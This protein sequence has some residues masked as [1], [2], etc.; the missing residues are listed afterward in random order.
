MEFEVFYLPNLVTD[1]KHKG[2]LRPSRTEHHRKG[3]LIMV[4]NT[5]NHTLNPSTFVPTL[6]IGVG[7]MG[8]FFTLRE[9]E[10]NAVPGGEE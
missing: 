6:F 10:L 7:E 2:G 1:T 5:H 9:T 8:C 3:A 4:Y